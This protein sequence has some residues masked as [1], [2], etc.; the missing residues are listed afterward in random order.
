MKKNKSFKEFYSE[1][2][3]ITY[4]QVKSRIIVFSPIPP[5]LASF[6]KVSCFKN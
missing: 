2:K 3:K 1:K 6:A 4:L 5:I